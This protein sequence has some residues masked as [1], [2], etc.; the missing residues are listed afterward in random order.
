MTKITCEKC[1][2]QT[3]KQ[4]GT[5]IIGKE[6]VPHFEPYCERLK[7]WKKRTDRAC[8]QYEGPIPKRELFKPKTLPKR[9]WE[10][11]DW[12]PKLGIRTRR[13]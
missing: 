10:E 2:H 4:K 3:L 1:K 5:I 9:P 12:D 7:V 8:Q 6:K 11:P 13:R